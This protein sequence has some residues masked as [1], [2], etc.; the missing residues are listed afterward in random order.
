VA[1]AIR[2]EV[3]EFVAEMDG[4]GRVTM[5]NVIRFD[6]ERIQESWFHEQFLEAW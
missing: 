3:F 4:E 2:L 6:D 5:S 1:P